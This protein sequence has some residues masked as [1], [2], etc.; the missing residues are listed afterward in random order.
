VLVRHEMSSKMPELRE[1]TSEADA[2]SIA[3]LTLAPCASGKPLQVMENHVSDA[4]YGLEIRWGNTAF[5]RLV[6]LTLEALLQRPS[7]WRIP[8]ASA[9]SIRQ[10]QKVSVRSPP[11]L[12]YRHLSPEASVTG[13]DNVVQ[14]ATR[15][16]V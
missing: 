4:P 2:C 8:E 6:T 15:V 14:L 9:Y 10:V 12:Y 13:R 5:L 7:P 3:G 11:L 1:K 16:A